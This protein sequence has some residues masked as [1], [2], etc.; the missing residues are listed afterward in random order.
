[1]PEPL[2]RFEAAVTFAILEASERRSRP[3]SEISEPGRNAD[4]T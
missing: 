4:L 3:T 2:D 1:V